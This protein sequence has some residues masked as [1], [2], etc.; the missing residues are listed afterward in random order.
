MPD[1]GAENGEQQPS[2][3]PDYKVFRQRRGIFSRLRKPDVPSLRDLRGDSP[4]GSGDRER[5]RFGRRLRS[6]PI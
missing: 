4:K 1:D 3:P 5:G 2:G 6:P